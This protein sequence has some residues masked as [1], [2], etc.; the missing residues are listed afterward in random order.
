MKTLL[1]TKRHIGTA[2]ILLFFG[3]IGWYAVGRAHNLVHGAEIALNS[4]TDGQVVNEPLLTLSGT[5]KNAKS[6]SI[7]DRE[8]FVSEAY[9]FAE[10]ILLLPG[11]NVITLKGEDKF[12]KKTEEQMRVVYRPT[13]T[14][15][16]GTLIS[17]SL[18]NTNAKET[19]N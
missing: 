7:N 17:V 19:R 5:A 11:Y 2:S 15:S 16:D 3:L 10:K 6:F 18:N 4:L 9:N 12:G 8:V 1:S 13:T 14:E